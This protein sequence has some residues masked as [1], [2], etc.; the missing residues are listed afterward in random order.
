MK[1]A[2][3]H[4]K[5]KSKSGSQS[6]SL[7]RWLRF[8]SIT[9]VSRGSFL[10]RIMVFCRSQQGRWDF[11]MSHSAT[12]LLVLLRPLVLGFSKNRC[13]VPVRVFAVVGGEGRAWSVFRLRP[14]VYV[15]R[16]TLNHTL[17]LFTSCEARVRFCLGLASG[18]L[19]VALSVCGDRLTPFMTKEQSF[20]PFLGNRQSWT[21]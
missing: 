8:G 20:T 14:P 13:S 5:W 17:A 2:H 9:C 6:S 18:T 3:R 4:R 16:S 19:R 21:N 12:N 11:P 15:G 7:S 10:S 1:I